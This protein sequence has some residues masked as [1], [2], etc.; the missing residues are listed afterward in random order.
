MT[1]EQRRILVQRESDRARHHLAQADEMMTLGHWDMAANRQYYACYHAVQALFVSHEVSGATHKGTISQ[2]S[3]YFV[4][5][6]II[7]VEYGSFLSRMMQLRTKAD[8]NC[9]YDI[10]KDEV[11]SLSA[12]THDFVETVLNLVKKHEY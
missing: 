2:F 9:Y 10:S 11:Q 12:P 1:S 8:Y 3:L 4:K 5:T 6:G 7:G